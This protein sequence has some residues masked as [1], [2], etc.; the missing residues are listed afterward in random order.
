MSKLPILRPFYL[1]SLNRQWH[2]IDWKEFSSINLDELS[3]KLDPTIF[4]KILPFVAYCNIENEFKEGLDSNFLKLYRLAQL[5]I[6]YLV[7]VHQQLTDQFDGVKKERDQ[8]ELNLENQRIELE[9]KRKELRL[10]RKEKH[11]KMKIFDKVNPDKNCKNNYSLHS[12]SYCNKQFFSVVF[13]HSHIE[14]RHGPIATISAPANNLTNPL[15]PDEMTEESH[16]NQFELLHSLITQLQIQKE[17]HSEQD[18]DKGNLINQ[19][20]VIFHTFSCLICPKYVLIFSESSYLFDKTYLWFN[21][22]IS[23]FPKHFKKMSVDRPIVQLQ[24]N[25]QQKYQNIKFILM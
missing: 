5:L 6:E 4:H 20:Q 1:Q 24:E 15:K 2:H 14:R 22:T 25:T 7:L 19:N 13:L 3:L 10:I 9:E 18:E 11:K 23:H 21:C 12:C 8:F 16:Q 17:S